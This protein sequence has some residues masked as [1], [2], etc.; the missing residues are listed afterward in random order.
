VSLLDELKRRNVIRVG[1]AYTVAAWLVIQIAETLFPL[2]GY[3]ETPARIV[4][5]V[6]A[7][8]FLP[9][10]VFAWAFELTPDGLKR[11]RDVDRSRSIARETGK[12]LDRIIMA[13]LSLALAYFA[14][15]QFVLDPRH[16]AVLQAEKAQEV[17]RAHQAGRSEALVESYGDKSIAVL[18][19][20]DMSPGQDQAYLSEGIA[21]ELLNLLGRIP[22][23]RVISRS[24]AFSFKGQSLEIPEIARRLD[25]AHV[26]DGSVRQAGNR[27]RITAQLID[28]RSDTQLW[29]ESYDRTLDD[30]F[31]IQDEISANVVEQLKIQLLGEPLAAQEID[32]E[33]YSLYLQARH[34][35][36]QVSPESIV[37]ARRLFEQ[38]LAIEPDYAPAW[39]GLSVNYFRM[40]TLG[41]IPRE[42]AHPGARHASDRAI[43]L[44][45]AYAPAFAHAAW[46]SIFH[47]ND[48]AAA[49]SE[50]KV[51]LKL[52]PNDPW[53]IGRAAAFLF[54]TGR[55]DEAIEL[56]RREIAGDPLYLPAYYNQG[57]RFLATRRWGEVIDAFRTTLRLN[58]RV[59]G[60]HFG[61]SE[62]LMQK[63]ELEA[64]LRE[65]EQEGH[66]AYRQI[67]LALVHHAMGEPGQSDRALATLIGDHAADFASGIAAVF[68][69]RGE[70][71]A[72]FEWLD[73]AAQNRDLAL[74]EYIFSKL[75]DPLREDPRWLPFLESIGK[76]PAQLAAIDL[77]VS[78]PR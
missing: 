46:L 3:D 56:G 31:A 43:E 38:A 11:D 32:P 16:E 47:D 60:G 30:I 42:E 59:A 20:R 65:L 35:S 63:G 68:A 74:P 19:F 14:F 55:L 37:E 77:E 78:P 71:D 4:V 76:S 21:E 62:A 28:A 24:S 48:L 17:E 50:L 52:Q 15:D 39:N 72:A 34:L 44:D 7:I 45:P 2:F 41:L 10:V 67:G 5:I 1:A 66:E 40:S 54:L 33:A 53:I 64:A 36:N 29:S 8:G 6:L 69:F 61:I 26:L 27:V 51:A 12:R 25:V 75:L 58:P 23:L 49:A 13:V 73:R 18:A 22:E 9:A 70:A 57:V